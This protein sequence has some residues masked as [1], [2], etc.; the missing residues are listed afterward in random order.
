MKLYA[1]HVLEVAYTIKAVTQQV[2]ICVFLWVE[3]LRLLR[4]L[5]VWVSFIS[6]VLPGLNRNKQNT[7]R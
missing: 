5:V 1:L 3:S 4:S 2:V 7:Q 6:L